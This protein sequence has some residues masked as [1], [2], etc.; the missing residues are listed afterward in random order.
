MEYTV[1]YTDGHVPSNAKQTEITTYMWPGFLAELIEDEL[2]VWEL[3][4]S[5]VWK[6]RP[7]IM[8]PPA[9]CIATTSSQA[10]HWIQGQERWVGLQQGPLRILK[11]QMHQ[12]VQER[13][14]PSL[15]DLCK[16]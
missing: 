8:A 14:R 12:Q 3:C 11:A 6:L 15:L 9:N 4:S 2:T 16:A 13:Q 10:V 5:V 7:D 1:E